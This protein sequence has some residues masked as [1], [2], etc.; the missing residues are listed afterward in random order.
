MDRRSRSDS[1]LVQ[2][3]AVCWGSPAEV[4]PDPAKLTP[5]TAL[6]IGA[7]I[8]FQLAGPREP[9]SGTFLG[10]SESFSAPISRP[11]FIFTTCN[12][13]HSVWNQPSDLG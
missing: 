1:A 3:L 10:L 7:S 12:E 9:P 13:K 4:S 5:L 8:P 6:R 11:E 2:L